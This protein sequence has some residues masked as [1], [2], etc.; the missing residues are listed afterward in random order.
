MVI[1]LIG[2]IIKTSRFGPQYEN[3]CN[4]CISLNK[5][6]KCVKYSAMENNVRCIQYISVN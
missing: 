6:G 3:K 5:K 4:T 2:K 1:Y